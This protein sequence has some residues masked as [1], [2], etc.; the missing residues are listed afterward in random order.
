MRLPLLVAPS[1]VDRAWFRPEDAERGSRVHA[2]IELFHAG[3]LTDA[4][5]DDE[6]RPFLLAYQKFLADACFHVDAVEERLCD[7]GLMCAGTLDLRGRFVDRRD[8]PQL[9][10]RI[11]VID[12]KTGHVPPW[13][14]YQ[15][16]GYVR[17]LP[18]M[19]ARRVTRWCLNLRAD[20]QYRLLPLTRRTDE[21]VFLAALT[22]AQAKRGWL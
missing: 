20:A 4:H 8:V 1:L 13:V 11:D 21:Q 2:A 17:L 18:T 3:T 7:A 22:V 19:V 5:L 12:V 14:G 10:D 9:G 16:S 15:V 6:I